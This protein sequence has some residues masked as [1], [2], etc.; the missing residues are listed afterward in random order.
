MS[1]NKAVKG[2]I[3]IAEE[4]IAAIAVAAAM[5]VEGV[6]EMP[7]KG[8]G[9]FFGKKGHTKCLKITKEENELVLEIEII[10][11]FGTMVQVVAEKVQE[12]VQSAVETMTGL[13]VPAVHV[14][15]AGI[16]KQANEEM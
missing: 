15:V 14:S 16:V 11:N 3:E 5:E 2:Q 12:K 4:V 8:F 6:A 7:T 10:V 9:E 1:E 13:Q